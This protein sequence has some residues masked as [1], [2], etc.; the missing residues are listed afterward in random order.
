MPNGTEGSPSICPSSHRNL[1]ILSSVSLRPSPNQF[2][3]PAMPQMVEMRGGWGG[4]LLLTSQEK[5]IGHLRLSWITWLSTSMQMYMYMQM[6]MQ[7][8]MALFLQF[9]CCAPNAPNFGFVYVHVAYQ[10][11]PPPPLS[12]IN[13]KTG[14]RD[15]FPWYTLEGPISF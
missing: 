13:T 6:Y 5:V 3:Q 1:R 12:S 8:Y 11:P 10:C 15:F 14:R 9:P 2:L 4:A 7:M